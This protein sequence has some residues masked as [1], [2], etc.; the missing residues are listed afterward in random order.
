MYVHR[1]DSICVSGSAGLRRSKH[2]PDSGKAGST[3][4]WR[5]LADRDWTEVDC[6]ILSAMPGGCISMPG[7][8]TLCGGRD[9]GVLVLVN[10]LLCTPYTAG[11]LYI[12]SWLG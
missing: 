2:A 12:K 10:Y 4:R 9:G 6:D 8:C 11:K 3:G 1:H 5:H 7:G